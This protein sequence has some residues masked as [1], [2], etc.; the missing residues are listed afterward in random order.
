[1][2]RAPER[3]APGLSVVVASVSGWPALA[4][5]LGSLARQRGRER[6]EVIV[7]EGSGDGAALSCRERYPWAR[8][9][10]V[11]PTRPIPALRAL[12]IRE[13]RAPLVATTEAHCR[14]DQGWCEA[15]LEAHARAP[16]AAAIGGA[17]DNGSVERLVDWAAYLSEYAPFMRPFAP[18]PEQDLPGPNVSYKRQ[19]LLG[20]C[21]DLLEGDGAWEHVLHARLAARGLGLYRD[22]AIVAYHCRRFGLAEFLAQRY[23]FGRAYAAARVAAAPGVVRAFRAATAPLLPPLLLWRTVRRVLARGRCRRELS[24]ALPLLALCQ[25]AWAVGELLGYAVGDGG[26]G[27]RVR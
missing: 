3:S 6:V 5:C 24:R 25:A 13:A 11:A 1:V 18:G 4:G 12:G 23:R 14:L 21:G 22:P 27:A 7:V 19:P 8:V 20:A 16:G 10:A 26:A 17:V 2:E 9:L 15:I